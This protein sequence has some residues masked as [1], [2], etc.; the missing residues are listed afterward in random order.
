MK[1]PSKALF[2][3]LRRIGDILMCTPSIRAFKKQYPDCTLDFL[4]EIP[5]TLQGNP[6]LNSIITVD[7]NKAF[8]PAY[9]F[10]LIRKIRSAGYNLVVDFL[11][12]PRSA[13]YAYFSNAQLRVSYGFGHR[14][15][16]YN[17]IPPKP[18]KPMYAALD[19]L[20]LLAAI[21]INSDEPVL[22]FY[23]S[24]NDKQEAGRII[25]TIDKPIITISP[26]SRREY[27]RW[28]LEGYASLGDLI[29][30]NLNAQVLILSGPGEEQF[31]RIVA[32][33]MTAKVIVPEIARLGVLGAIF[34]KTSLHIGNDNGPKHIAVACGAPTF[35]IFGPQNPV[36]WTYPD[37][38]HH[39]SICPSE[40]CEQCRRGKHHAGIA[41]IAK[42]PVESV[43]RRIYEMTRTIPELRL[44]YKRV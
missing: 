23:P 4:T 1:T 44:S 5:E 11:A 27:R 7:R 26:V 10:K 34:K 9:Q 21:G 42:I 20:N 32:E 43:W 30:K 28:P 6:Y 19:K 15:W 31:A 17:M 22:E 14:K 39:Q 36:S 24:E 3:Q 40:F 29:A 18:D 33:K 12:N 8:S 41:C 38:S 25:S 13:Y 35:A 2:I 37:N 16:A